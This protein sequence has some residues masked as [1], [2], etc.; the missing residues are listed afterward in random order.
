MRKILFGLALTAILAACSTDSYKISGS[1]EDITEGT[2]YLRKIGMQNF[3]EVDTAEIV[4]GAYSFIGSVEYPELYLIFVN[5]ARTP[6]AF[7]LENSSVS[8]KSNSEKPEDAVIKG[9]KLSDIFT[10]FN[11]EVPHMDKIEKMREEF[12]R[13]QSQGDNATLES[14]MAD[15]DTIVEEQK[16]YYR[17]F[18][19]A[20]NNNAVGAFIALNMAQSMEMEELEGLA[21]TMKTNM[22]DHP[23]VTQ[24]FEIIEPLKAQMELEA[25]LAVG[26]EAP[27]FTLKD[28]NGNDVS[29]ES[30]RGKYV[31]LD[32]WAAWCR[33]C[34]EENPNLVEVYKKFGGENFEIIS[35][36]LDQA[37]EAWK[38]AVKEDKLTWTLLHD[39]LGNVANNYAIQS[40]PSTWLLDKEGKIIF[41]D[42]RG[43]AIGATVEALLQQ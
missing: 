15:M 28:I 6:I 33:P 14:I 8:I 19:N 32:F 34:R 40:I 12:M 23:Y 30:F 42:L 20:N 7:F 16:N 11:K 24:L 5:E 13:A 21:L 35:V 38:G 1:F 41:K 25:A 17:E 26:Q 43:E 37:E 39:P 10:K 2:V 3:V 9:S 4:G 22:G 27:L 36:S 29:L 18:V 31:F